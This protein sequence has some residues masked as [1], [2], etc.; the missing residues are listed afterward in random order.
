MKYLLGIICVLC[1]CASLNVE[2]QGIKFTKGNWSAILEQAKKE[3]KLVFIDCYTEWC[4]PCKEMEK[5]VFLSKEVGDFY[6]KNFINLKVDMERGEGPMVLSMYKISAF[7]TFLFV[8]P[9]GDEVYCLVGSKTEA[10]MLEMGKNALASKTVTPVNPR[11]KKQ[12]E[13][14]G[15]EIPDF[16][17][18][19]INGEMVSF[20]SFR[21][22]YVYVDMWATWCRPCCEEIPYMGELEKKFHGKN[23]CFV[24]LSCDKNLEAWKKKVTNDKM[25]GVQL[26]CEGDPKFMEFFGVEGIPHFI[27]IDPQGRVVNPRM[28]R[29]SQEITEET[30]K[31]LEG[32]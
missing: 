20:S 4:Q 12:V 15:K 19:D 2:A 6:N 18:R 7:P 11:V 22:K 32:I 17:Y 16:A 1:C 24:S 21:G 9:D 29:P 27:L 14:I 13:L 23:I 3:K 5:G 26:N 10:E 8:N 28:S 31:R 30:L 25:G